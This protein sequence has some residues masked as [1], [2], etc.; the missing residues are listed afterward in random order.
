MEDEVDAG[1]RSGA[2]SSMS[3]TTTSS[4]ISRRNSYGS[5]KQQVAA[6]ILAAYDQYKNLVPDL[7]KELNKV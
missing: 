6:D 2:T 4:R 7:S 1:D 5:R 3:S